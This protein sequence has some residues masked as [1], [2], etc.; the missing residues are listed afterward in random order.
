MTPLQSLRE[1]VGKA[2]LC[3]CFYCDDNSEALICKRCGNTARPCTPVN[4]TY[5]A[6]A[7]LASLPDEG[8]ES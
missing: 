5:Y 2:T 3:Y 7:L 8:S 6:A 4:D 1:R